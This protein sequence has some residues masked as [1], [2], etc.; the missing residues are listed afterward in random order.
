MYDVYQT[1]N[2]PVD[3]RIASIRHGL[4]AMSIQTVS[5]SLGVNKKTLVS[6]LGVNE[7]TLLRKIKDHDVLDPSSSERLLRVMEIERRAVEVLGSESLARE[8]LQS[9]N[10]VLGTSPLAKLDTELGAAQV[11]RVLASI[12]YGMPV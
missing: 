9:V 11:R 8:W 2:Q 6:I 7:R 4:P 3:A 10:Q 1:L 12:E 5:D